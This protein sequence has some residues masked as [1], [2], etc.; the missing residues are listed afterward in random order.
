ME[1]F[2]YKG[3]CGIC[4]SRCFGYTTVHIVKTV[5]TNSFLLFK[6]SFHCFADLLAPTLQ[7]RKSKLESRKLRAMSMRVDPTYQRLEDL[8]GILHDNLSWANETSPIYDK[9]A[10]SG[11]QN[12]IEVTYESLSTDES[13][14]KTEAAP[15][16]L[17]ESN[18]NLNPT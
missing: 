11:V 14:A 13:E 8:G 1:L 16:A 7:G 17:G 3:G 10:A 6:I 2:I 4:V 9:V 5:S 12:F 18:P 15:A